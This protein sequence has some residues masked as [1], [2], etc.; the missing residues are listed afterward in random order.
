MEKEMKFETLSKGKVPVWLS[1]MELEV[2]IG[3]VAELL[4]DH[5]GIDDFTREV[6]DGVMAQLSYLELS[7]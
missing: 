2:V 3:F 5:S 6:F 1:E 7:A 4:D